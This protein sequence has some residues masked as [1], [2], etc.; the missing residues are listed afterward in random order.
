MIV[1][2]GQGYLF[3]HLKIHFDNIIYINEV[4]QYQK[5]IP[6]DLIIHFAS[7]SD[8]YD[9]NK[10]DMHRTMIDGTVNMVNLAKRMNAHFVF[11]STMG[12]YELNDDYSI[13]KYAM[14]KYIQRELNSYCILRI[15]RVYSSDRPKGLI[16]QIKEDSIPQEDYD[17]IVKYITINDFVTFFL[18]NYKKQGIF[19]VNLDLYQTSQIKQIKQKFK[20]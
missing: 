15:P 10:S 13:F 4:K 6:D 16:K 12:I 8:K 18:D 2:G 3:S 7:P 11:A 19:E 20:I 9:F 5:I 17:T 14:E 1:T